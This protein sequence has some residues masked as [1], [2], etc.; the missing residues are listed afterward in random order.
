MQL[1]PTPNEE[2][3]YETMGQIEKLKAMT[4]KPIASLT[5][6]QKM[7]LRVATMTQTHAVADRAVAVA[8]IRALLDANIKYL[9]GVDEPWTAFI[10]EEMMDF[11]SK[12]AAEAALLESLK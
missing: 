1:T 8:T 12:A 4:A 3:R 2:E 9:E 10:D 5:E 6:L 11:P 7:E